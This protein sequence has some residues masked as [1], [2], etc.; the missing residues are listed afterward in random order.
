M[1]QAVH[2]RLSRNLGTFLVPLT[3]TKSCVCVSFIFPKESSL[4]S[5]THT[6]S[7]CPA[8][9]SL[10]QHFPWLHSLALWT[11]GFLIPQPEIYFFIPLEKTFREK[12]RQ[13]YLLL[14]PQWLAECLF[15]TEASLNICLNEKETEIYLGKPLTKQEWVVGGWTPRDRLTNK[16]SES[17]AME[18]S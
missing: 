6:F 1:V 8:V 4:R 2:L 16:V 15:G 18:G 7:S 12:P 17:Q 10:S 9:F 14:Y 13:S 11:F 5:S 3:V